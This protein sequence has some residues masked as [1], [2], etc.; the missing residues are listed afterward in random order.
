[1]AAENEISNG[2]VILM[3][4]YKT[5]R[6]KY[7]VYLMVSFTTAAVSWFLLWIL[8]PLRRLCILVIPELWVRC[9]NP[10]YLFLLSNLIILILAS[11]AGMLSPNGSPPAVDLYTEFIRKNEGGPTYYY[12][13]VA[14]DSPP[15][16][17]TSRPPNDKSK[18]PSSSNLIVV[19]N[20][21][22]MSD[23]ELN[24]RVEAFIAKINHEIRL[25]R[26]RFL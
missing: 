18:S 12:S 6:K 5:N 17:N 3:K 10:R 22:A 26:Q 8:P 1:M 20:E 25:E 24:R 13:D 23:E 21:A 11:M 4:K 2:G 14:A 19:E 15:R 7:V 9:S 16:D